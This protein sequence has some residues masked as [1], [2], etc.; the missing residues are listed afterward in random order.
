MYLSRI[1]GLRKMLFSPL[2]VIPAHS[3]SPRSQAKAVIPAKAG[4]YGF[5]FCINVVFY[6]SSAGDA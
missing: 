5:E 6:Y 1:S 4:I 2:P 3:M